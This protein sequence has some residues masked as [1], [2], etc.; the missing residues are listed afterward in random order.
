MPHKHAAFRAL[1]TSFHRYLPPGRGDDSMP[2][3]AEPSHAASRCIAPLYRSFTVR[4]PPFG[5]KGVQGGTGLHSLSI[6][7]IPFNPLTTH[8]RA[9]YTLLLCLRSFPPLL[10]IVLRQAHLLFPFSS[11]P[12]TSSLAFLTLFPS[13]FYKPRAVSLPSYSLSTPFIC[14]LPSLF[15]I[16][17]E[18]ER[19]SFVS[20]VHR[21]FA[22][23]SSPSHNPPP[24]LPLVD[25]LRA[26]PVLNELQ[27]RD[28]ATWV[29]SNF[30]FYP[31]TPSYPRIGCRIDTESN[32]GRE[33]GAFEGVSLVVRRSFSLSRIF[34][35]TR[36]NLRKFQKLEI[37]S[38]R[39]ARV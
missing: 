10:S 34:P 21:D 1:G 6:E 15:F 2:S 11:F 24:L 20:T 7:K 32:E 13:S 26:A 27:R 4:E 25:T 9:R 38:Q 12:F 23:G 29:P 36:R 39:R 14:P 18:A 31:I 3:R 8:P 17:L 37:P 35:L 16:Y 33:R 22:I 28:V 30:A 5:G 19:T